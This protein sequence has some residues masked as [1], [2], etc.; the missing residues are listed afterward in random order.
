MD[1][2]KIKVVVTGGSGFIGSVLVDTLIDQNYEVVIIDDLSANNGQVYKNNSATYYNWDINDDLL[3]HEEIFN[4]SKYVFHLAAESR[5]GPAI[6]NP[7]RAK[8]I[9]VDGTMKVMEY[10]K[11]YGVD[12]VIY[13]STSSVY[14]SPVTLPTK[15]D[16]PIDCLNPYATSKYLGED[17]VR[18][19]NSTHN[20]KAVI[21]RYF[22]VFGERSPVNGQYAPVIGIFQKQKEENTPLTIV[23]DG[24]QRR[25]FIHVNDV[26]Q[27]NILAATN[28]DVTT[29]LF[30][31]GSG[32]NISVN[33]IASLI[34]SNVTYIPPRSGEARHTLADISL[35]K[36]VL[37]FNPTITV[38]QYLSK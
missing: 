35:A 20:V 15:E 29:G 34:S 10:S 8:R 9:N 23:G 28:P 3:P 18:L 5:I 31:I 14:G 25:D 30:N 36:S 38:Q 13:S 12:K 2:S 27:A 26:V 4:N 16:S 19:Y 22:N 11:I 37:G 7:V 21:F 1:S 24:E 6:L 33:E 32:T 17:M